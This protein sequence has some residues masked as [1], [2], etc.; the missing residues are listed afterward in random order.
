MEGYRTVLWAL[1]ALALVALAGSGC[2][3]LNPAP[4]YA[5]PRKLPP[6]PTLEQVIQVVNANSS[7]IQSFSTDQARLSAPGIPSLRASIAF[8]RPRRLRLRAETSLTGPELDVGSNDELFWIWVAR[9]PP[10]YYCRHEQ[11]AG[12]PLR[13]ALPVEPEWLIEAFGISEFD[14]GLP[15]WGPTPRPGGRLEIRTTRQTADGPAVKITV[16]DGATGVLLEQHAYDAQGQL[17]VSALAGHHRQEPL[18]GLIMP[19][20]VDIRC[21][22]TQLA[23]RIDLG[24]VRINRP[25]VSTASLWTMPALDQVPMVD[26]GDPNLQFVPGC[27]PPGPLSELSARPS[28]PRHGWN[29]MPF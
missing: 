20:I 13:R 27:P 5:L 17:V 2:A 24:N 16:V 7:Q 23:M 22:R 25:F 21:P 18:S 4:Q 14:P 11:F 12:S 3:W 6:S 15:H 9:Q 19:R 28:R 10:L 29:R 8:E 1:A 26:L